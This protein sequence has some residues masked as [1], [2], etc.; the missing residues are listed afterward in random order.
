[1]PDLETIGRALFGTQ[2]QSDLARALGVADRTMR[3]WYS[4]AAPI[5][6][7]AWQDMRRLCIERSKELAALAKAIEA[8]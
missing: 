7:G 4:G 3:R 5:P 1:M 8:P 2:W 6:V